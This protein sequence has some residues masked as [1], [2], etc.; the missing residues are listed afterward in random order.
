LRFDNLVYAYG[1]V[2]YLNAA[3]QGILK[4]Q[5]LLPNPRQLLKDES[6]I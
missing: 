5:K 4:K 6:D 3:I 1:Q 2:G